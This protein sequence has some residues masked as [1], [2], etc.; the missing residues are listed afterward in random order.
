MRRGAWAVT[1]C[2]IASQIVSLATLAVLYRLISPEIFGVFAIALLVVNF[3]RIF[4]NFG[5]GVASVQDQDLS[6]EE[7]SALFHY[8]GRIAVMTAGVLGLVSIPIAWFFGEFALR[9][10]L[11]LP[12]L[13]LPFT[14]V[15]IQHQAL[16]ERKMLLGRLAVCRLI[17]QL[18][19]SIFAIVMAYRGLG[20][21][22]LTT[23]FA[24]ETTS[25]G[26]AL[27]IAEPWRPSD[28]N[29]R[30]PDISR[31][32]KF[33]AA[34]TLSSLAFW[35]TQ[36]FDTLIVGW[37]GG[38]LAVGLY[39]QA[40]NLMMKPVLLVTTP[41]TAVML[42]TLAR[43]LPGSVEYRQLLVGFYRFVGLVLLPCS[44]G[45]FVLADDVM[46]VLGGNQ[47]Q[48]AGILLRALAPVIAVQGFINIA[49]SVFAAAGRADRLLAGSVVIALLL[50]Q[51]IVAGWW[52]GV[53]FGP[54]GLG[55]PLGVAV[56]YSAVTMGVIFLPY[57]GFCLKT[58]GVPMRVLL[59]ALRKPAIAS[60]LMGAAVWTTI[61]AIDETPLRRLIVGTVT[62]VTV[63]AFIMWRELTQLIAK[64]NS[65]D[66][67]TAP[68]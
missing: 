46:L 3:A 34:Y 26:V 12:T 2:H 43:S 60:L 24:V 9:D 30:N 15:G 47:W 19:G 14:V 7:R 25:L 28:K 66:N 61:I 37:L 56:A 52:F 64:S 13:A 23:Q 5:L 42:P 67:P 6:D 40:F 45:L 22:S 54:A 63:F 21:W 55:G 50:C 59:V 44:V 4:A 8:G 31:F 68:D 33:G 10:A 16:L 57:L 62:G 17:A 58:V 53:W 29:A 41:V 35:L 36:N 49:G 48:T 11:I 20:I 38:K 1:A 32:K 18:I 39:S 27:W 51:G 65:E